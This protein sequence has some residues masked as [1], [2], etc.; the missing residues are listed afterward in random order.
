MSH[1]ARWALLVGLG[2]MLVASAGPAW[3]A[4]ADVRID[5]TLPDDRPTGD[6]VWGVT[7]AGLEMGRGTLSADQ[8]ATSASDGSAS[9]SSWTAALTICSGVCRNPV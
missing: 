5:L 1:R 4:S 8:L 7:R 2:S 3:A 6:L 9:T